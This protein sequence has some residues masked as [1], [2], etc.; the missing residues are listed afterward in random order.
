MTVDILIAD[1]EAPALD[2]LT[3]LLRADARV[4]EIYRAS[5]GAAALRVLSE[6]SVS[7]VFLD[8]H[9]PGLSGLDLARALQQFQQRPAVIF[10]TADDSR[11]IEAFDVAAVD[12][13][14]KPVRAER[15]AVALGRAI[16]ANL[17]GAPAVADEKIPVTVGS[18]TRL[19][20]RAD[21]RWVHAQGDYS[22]LWTASGSHLIRTPISE[23][24]ERWHSAG[25]VRIHRSYLVHRDAVTS[26]HL[27][28]NTPTVTLAEI[29]LPVSRRLTAS[30]R[31]RLLRS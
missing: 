13:V 23:L 19:I 27:S 1:D 9:M 22:R 8:I 18:D 21:V 7:V 25:F 4:G 17:A 15:L 6:A 11:A 12:Y 2:E 16:D 26:L 5:S 29:E 30:V 14:L 31:E 20:R 3:A 24:E 28:G 10:V